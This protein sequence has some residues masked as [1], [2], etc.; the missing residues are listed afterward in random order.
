[1][2][3]A[4]RQ[5]G[6]TLRE[7]NIW[8]RERAASAFLVVFGLFWVWGMTHG[9]TEQTRWEVA[10]GEFVGMT[11]PRKGQMIVRFHLPSGTQLEAE[12]S[13]Q[14]TAPKVGDRLY[15][16]YTLDENGRVDRSVLAD[17]WTESLDFVFVGTTIALLG[18]VLSVWFWVFMRD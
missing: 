18:I 13:R 16:R 17:A 5:L 9:A 4:C 3:I 15:I 7:K 8:W 6:A 11:K 1:M 12:V 10:E 14:G 2:F